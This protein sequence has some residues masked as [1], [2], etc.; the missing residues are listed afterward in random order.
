[1]TEYQVQRTDILGGGI[2]PILQLQSLRV[3]NERDELLIRVRPLKT[4]C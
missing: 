3:N 1:M 2:L 4:S